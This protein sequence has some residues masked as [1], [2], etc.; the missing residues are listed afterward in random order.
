MVQQGPEELQRVGQ[1]TLVLLVQVHAL[2]LMQ[3]G[4]EKARGWGWV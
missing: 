4:Q 2:V 3:G 1:L